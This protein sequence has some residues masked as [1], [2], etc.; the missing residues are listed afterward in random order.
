MCVVGARHSGKHGTVQVYLPEIRKYRV[1][2][3]GE[4]QERAML[5]AENLS[6]C[7]ASSPQARDKNGSN[8]GSAA[9]PIGGGTN[10]PENGMERFSPP[11]PAE[12]AAAPS[13]SSK[14]AREAEEKVEHGKAAEVFGQLPKVPN[15]EVAREVAR[16]IAKDVEQTLRGLQS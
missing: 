14:V 1:L 8:G 7:S 3:S 2:M 16:E 6:L 4:K 10:V 12:L 15:R 5:R 11:S 13:L 9:S